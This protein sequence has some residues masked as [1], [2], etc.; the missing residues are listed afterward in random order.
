MEPQ[1]YHKKNGGPSLEI[2]TDPE[3]KTL[4]VIEC[5]VVA[6]TVTFHDRA[7][8][9]AIMVAIETSPDFANGPAQLLKR[10]DTI[11]R[12][13]P[14]AYVVDFTRELARAIT[15]NGRTR[16]FGDGSG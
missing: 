6:G 9:V 10:K 1:V 12:A 5:G 2:R 8:L 13:R 4:T 14:L 3:P 16:Q 7:S 15:T 11:R